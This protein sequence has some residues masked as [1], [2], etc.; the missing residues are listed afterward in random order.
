M[1]VLKEKVLLTWRENTVAPS[2]ER[3]LESFDV[4]TEI[5]VAEVLRLIIMVDLQPANFVSV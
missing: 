3:I 4:Q 5:I 2:L 1:V